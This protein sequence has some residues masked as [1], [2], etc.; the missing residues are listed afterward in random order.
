M[1]D[2]ENRFRIQQKKRKSYLK[3]TYKRIQE[4]L[5]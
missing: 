5:D 2:N 1:K 4:E 3:E